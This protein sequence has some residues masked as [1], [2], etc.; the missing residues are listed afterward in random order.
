MFSDYSSV[1]ILRCSGQEKR[2]FCV[3]ERY[4]ETHQEIVRE[5]DRIRREMEKERRSKSTP[6][7]PGRELHTA[8][9][10]Q[11]RE[12]HRDRSPTRTYLAVT[13]QPKVRLS[14]SSCS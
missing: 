9:P 5:S 2:R 10:A 4:D 1:P 7:A 11:A 12:S 14:C 13:S 3:G 8:L 6:P